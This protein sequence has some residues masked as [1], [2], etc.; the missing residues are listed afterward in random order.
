MRVFVTGASGWIGAAVTDELLGAGHTVVGL[1][2]SQAAAVSLRSKGADVHPGDLDDLASL[3]T[4][5]SGA[6][7]VIHLAFKHDFTDYAA[8]GRT[9]RAAVTALLDTLAGSDRPLLVASGLV[10]TPGR[11]VT[12]ADVSPNVGPDAP[13]GG[14]ERLALDAAERGVRSLAVRFAPTVHGHADHG[15]IATLVEIARRRGV[16]G[17]IGDG[18]NRWPAVHRADAASVVRLALEQASP[19]AIVH[20]VAE[21]GIATREIAELIGAR[22]G[23][24]TA[25]I[26]AADAE[27]HFDWLARFFGA[28][29]PASSALTQARYGWNPTDPTLAD[30]LAG[31]AYG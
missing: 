4:G 18:S 14:T 7:A 31:G 25:A 16:A 3:R 20:A 2:R 9:E 30:D 21:D 11:L 29:I 15:F 24:P 12:E 28:D 8:S 10:V 22:F 6:D 27:A 23:L 19:G 26:A 13:R 1:A 5:A 17:F